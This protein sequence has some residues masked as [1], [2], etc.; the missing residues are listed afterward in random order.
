MQYAP[1]SGYRLLSS[2][3]FFTTYYILI[4]LYTTR[5]T[6]HAILFH[7]IR[8]TSYECQPTKDYVRNYKKNMQNEPKFRK[9]QMNVNKVL[10]MNYE[11]KDTWWTGKKRTQTNPNEPKFKKAKMNVTNYITMDYE[12][13][14]NWAICENEPN[15][16]CPACPE[17][18]RGE[19]RRM[20]PISKAKKCRTSRTSGSRQFMR[21]NQNMWPIC[22]TI[23]QCSILGPRDSTTRLSPIGCRSHCSS[24][25]TF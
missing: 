12:N 14:S 19:Q 2:S 20:D 13:I 11:K 9:S 18:G 25:A 5:C 3:S 21:C 15:Q 8:N 22:L 16:P 6:L 10:T 4:I 1:T 7:A 23:P 17:Q 24:R